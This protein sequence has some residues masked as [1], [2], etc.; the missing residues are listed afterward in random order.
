MPMESFG[1]LSVD[2]VYLQLTAVPLQ[3]TGLP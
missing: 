1:V 2:S 3:A